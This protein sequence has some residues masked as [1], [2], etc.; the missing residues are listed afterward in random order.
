MKKYQPLDPSKPEVKLRI[1]E[2]KEKRAIAYALGQLGGA[3]T[4]TF[5]FEVDAYQKAKA[6]EATVKAFLTDPDFS[7]GE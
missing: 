3:F 1:G 4:P 6:D 7:H 2:Y 5:Q